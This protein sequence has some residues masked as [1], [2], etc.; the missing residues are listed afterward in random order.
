M[1][2][3]ASSGYMEFSLYI[4]RGKCVLEPRYL[5]DRPYPFPLFPM[6]QVESQMVA[7]PPLVHLRFKMSPNKSTAH[8]RLNNFGPLLA[9]T[10]T[11]PSK[12]GGSKPTS[13]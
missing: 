3:L 13:H 8:L 10:A 1:F 11:K 12:R 4:A 9:G 6:F 7:L 5:S 2:S